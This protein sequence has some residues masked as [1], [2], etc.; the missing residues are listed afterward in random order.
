[1]ISVELGSDPMAESGD[2]TR[3]ILYSLKYLLK[4]QSIS[5]IKRYGFTRNISLYQ[6]NA[7]YIYTHT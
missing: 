4:S 1:M 7:I 5:K 2:K 3:I 6:T